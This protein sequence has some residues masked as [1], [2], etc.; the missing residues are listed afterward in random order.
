MN[1]GL[2]GDNVVEVALTGRVPCQV[3][4]PVRKR[5]LMVS[6]GNLA[7]KSN[8]DARAG[9]IIGKALENFDQEQGTIEVVVG[10]V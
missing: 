3:D 2:T 10:R 9:A 1:A 6:P 7:A 8:N 5:D 4:R